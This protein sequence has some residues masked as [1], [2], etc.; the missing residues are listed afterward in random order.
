MLAFF[1]NSI[2]AHGQTNAQKAG[3]VKNY[4]PNWASIN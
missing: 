4:K 2:G 1:S 3:S